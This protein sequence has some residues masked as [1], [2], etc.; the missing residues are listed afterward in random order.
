MLLNMLRQRGPRSSARVGSNVSNGATVTCSW[1][2]MNSS[3]IVSET[4]S[5]L[6]ESS[7]PILM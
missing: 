4:R 5:G 1:R 6:V 2:F 7:C 3:I